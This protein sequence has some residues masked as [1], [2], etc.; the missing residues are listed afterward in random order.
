MESS[1]TARDRTTR[2]RDPN[3]SDVTT[4]V[5]TLLFELSGVRYAVP[6]H[7]VVEVV[8]A[9]EIR[10]LPAAPPI[11]LGIIDVRGEI[12]PVFD[13]RVRFGYPHKPLA[14]SDQ[15]IIAQAGA[16][17]VALHVDSALGL[18]K[19]T[20]LAVQDAANLPNE[21]VHVAGVAPTDQ[22]LVLIHDLRS[23]LSQAEAHALDAALEA[24]RSEAERAP[25]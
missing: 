16:R 23:F 5:D 11:T 1:A 6:M 18:H 3:N 19:L 17:R 9:V 4:D 15:F 14:L 21:L 7:D 12:V 22:G 13:I 20:V 2:T 8:R 10:R 24:A 25:A